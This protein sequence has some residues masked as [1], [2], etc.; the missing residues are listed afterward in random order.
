M[1]A[2]I[3]S[4][5]KIREYGCILFVESSASRL[6]SLSRYSIK[7]IFAFYVFAYTH[8]AFPS[9]DTKLS[10]NDSLIGVNAV[11]RFHLA[12]NRVYSN[13]STRSRVNSYASD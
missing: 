6:A 10:G 5:K 13:D 9:N 12:S 1:F 2:R 3:Y 7:N 11:I 8:I 4:V